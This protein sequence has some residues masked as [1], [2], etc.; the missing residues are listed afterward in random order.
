MKA[1]GYEGLEQLDV[2]KCENKNFADEITD[3][4]DQLGEGCRSIHD[5]DKQRR[6]LEQEKEE[7]Q[8]IAGS[9]GGG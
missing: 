7:L 8:G 4:M 3:L 1:A 2:V 9:S 5:L 6:C